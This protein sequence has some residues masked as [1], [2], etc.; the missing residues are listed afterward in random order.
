MLRGLSRRALEGIVPYLVSPV[1]PVSGRV[2][3]DVLARL[4]ERLIAAGVHGLS[5]LGSTGEVAYL[6]SAQRLEVVRGVVQ[7]AAGRVPV[8]PGVAAFSVHDAVE[9][10]RR[11][12]ELGADG[13]VLM[14]QSYFPLPPQSVEAYFQAVAEAV[15]L[16]VVLYVNP[17][18]LG[19][20]LSVNQLDRLSQL[21]NVRYLK[22]ASGNTGKL[23]SVVRRV[24]ERLRL[25]SASAHIPLVVFQLG[26]VGWM[27]GPACLA[28]EACLRLYQLAC[29]REWEAAWAVQTRLWALNEVFQKYSLAACVKAGLE[30]QGLPV[31]PPLPPQ[32]PLD[33]AA[34]DEIRQAMEEAAREA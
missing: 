11:L 26:G 16:P 14:L 32:P 29:R 21:P 19:C 23:L 10:A 17:A 24:G 4:V 5:P 28:P 15:D 7:A 22:D 30:L 12:Q 8:V 3:Q 27:S 1:D 20:D 13:V 6:T 25:F 34:Y 2:R 18:V 33:R 31:G 9:Q